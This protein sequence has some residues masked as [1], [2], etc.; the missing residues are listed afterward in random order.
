MKTLLNQLWFQSNDCSEQ[1]ENMGI[2]ISEVSKFTGKPNKEIIVYLNYLTEKKYIRN[3]S[4]KP[5]LYEFT[6][7]GKELKS[8]S[9]IKHLINNV[10]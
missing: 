9:D 7:L 1:I 8:D 3:I 5:L 4:M 6:D 2:Q 10:A